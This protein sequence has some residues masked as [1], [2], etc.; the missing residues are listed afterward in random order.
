MHEI[1]L[2]YPYFHVRDDQWL[3]LAALYL[4]QVARIR[5]QDY[6]VRDSPT[7]AALRDGLGF[8]LDVDP[9]RQAVA[10]AVEFKELL[11][12]EER[13]LRRRYRLAIPEDA[14]P[15]RWEGPWFQDERNIAWIHRSQLGDTPWIEDGDLVD[16]MRDLGLAVN[17]RVDPLTGVRDDVKWVGMHPHLVAIYSC[18]LADRVARANALTP[19]TDDPQLF[20]LPRQGTV[21]ELAS[22]LLGNRRRTVGPIVDL[23]ACAA[24]QA[25][26]PQD[27]LQVPVEAIVRARRELADEFD[28]FRAH[29][30]GMGEDFAELGSVE[31]PAILQARVEAMV[32]RDLTKPTRELERGLRTLGMTPVRAVLGLKSLELPAIAA[33]SAHALDVSPVAGAGGMIAVQLFS[34]TRAALR[35]SAEQRTSA[36]GYLLS[37]QREF[38][39]AGLLTVLRRGP[40][41][42]RIRRMLGR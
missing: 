10:V 4:P 30:Q 6:P 12:R 39:S 31:D 3:K 20:T 37:L 35:T 19:V 25:V 38:E 17:V 41:M 14:D 32:N 15:G 21:E 40:R 36:A 18:V 2:Y 33:L 24:L 9:A 13:A 42:S 26:I 16:R 28:A 29:L 22:A 27:I 8:L 1:G 34:S 5:P 23:Y 7:A 11:D